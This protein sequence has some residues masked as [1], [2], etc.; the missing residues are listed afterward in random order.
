[1]ETEGIL[2]KASGDYGLTEAELRHVQA[3]IDAA[4]PGRFTLR[5]LFGRDRWDALGSHGDKRDYGTRFRASYAKRTIN[6]VVEDGHKSFSVA[7][8]I[9]R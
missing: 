2:T 4:P 3:I 1:M 5:Q 6:G 9:L 8:S 7:Y